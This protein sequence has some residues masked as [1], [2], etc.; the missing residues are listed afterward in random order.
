[1]I[2]QCDQLCGRD[3]TCYGMGPYAGDWGG[4]YCDECVQAVWKYDGADRSAYPREVD[5]WTEEQAVAALSRV[6]INIEEAQTV[7]GA[8]LRNV[9][10]IVGWKGGHSTVLC[11]NDDALWNKVRVGALTVEGAQRVLGRIK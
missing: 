1:M 10:G 2:A 5:V 8:G 11:Q 3:A 4:N 9:P 6:G 7:T